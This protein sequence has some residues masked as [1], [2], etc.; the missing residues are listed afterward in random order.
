M[1]KYLYISYIFYTG[2]GA[3]YPDEVANLQRL[4]GGGEEDVCLTQQKDA[5]ENVMK[6]LH[7]MEVSLCIKP[8]S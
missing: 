5:F 4:I 7:R 6:I 8:A 1:C 3:K 2:N